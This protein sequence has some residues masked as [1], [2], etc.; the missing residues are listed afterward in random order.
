MTVRR[1]LLRPSAYLDSVVLLALQRALAAAPGVEQAAAVM[2]TPANRELLAEAGLLPEGLGAARADDLVVVVAAA[3]GAAAETALGRV[4]ELLAARRGG[5]G[6][7][8]HRPRSLEG[9]LRAL[10]EARWTL[11][12]VPGRYAVEAA[13]GALAT[14]RHVFLFSDNVPLAEEVELKREAAGRGLLVL[15]PDCGTAV[16]AGVGLGFANRVRRGPVGVVAASGTGLQALL[17]HLDELGTGVSHAIGTGGRDLTAEV[18][19]V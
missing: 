11:V 14:G 6:G 1:H 16:V 2:A 17:C 4:D 12:S 9:A 3:D 8:A 5:G 13:R 10:P 15:G 18:G 19:A 7:A